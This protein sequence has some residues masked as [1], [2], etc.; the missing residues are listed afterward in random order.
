MTFY[1]VEILSGLTII[2]GFE[3]SYHSEYIYPV[4]N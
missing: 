4:K 3:L 2:L 1:L